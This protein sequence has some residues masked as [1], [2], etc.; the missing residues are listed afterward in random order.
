MEFFLNSELKCLK[1]K[2]NN[3]VKT[4]YLTAF[5]SVQP[6]LETMALRNINDDIENSNLFEID[7]SKNIRFKLKQLSIDIFGEDV[8][9]D[10]LTAFLQ[11]HEDS[12]EDLEIGKNF[13]DA[14]YEFSFTRF[15]N[16]KRLTINA[17][18]IPTDN[19]FYSRLRPNLSIKKL[20][21]RG[22]LKQFTTKELF[23][24]FPNI[25]T[26]VI[27]EQNPDNEE[28]NMSNE[29]MIY[30]SNNLNNLKHLVIPKLPLDV[31]ADTLKFPALKSFHVERMIQK[32]DW[33]TFIQSNPTIERLSFRWMMFPNIITDV[34]YE[35]IAKSLLNLQHL[36]LGSGITDYKGTLTNIAL[37]CRSLKV[38][39]MMNYLDSSVK[40]M[41]VLSQRDKEG[42]RISFYTYETD[43]LTFPEEIHLWSNEMKRQLF[44]IDGDDSSSGDS[45]G[46]EG[47]W[48]N[49]WDSDDELM[50]INYESSDNS[51]DDVVIFPFLR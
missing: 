10:Y 11:K 13:G 41:E 16:L 42:L 36:T 30:M 33:T 48:Q 44:D 47:D 3:D 39:Q 12:L 51:E 14:I 34:E 50:D 8:S 9:V 27:K 31:V 19:R 43:K 29:L 18:K 15:R 2:S 5:L 46:S 37:N 20:I 45:T 17:D 26:L 49:D 28:M 32:T 1:I 4:E 35:I 25:E 38:L 6:H 40:P 22:K 23:G 7:I 24:Q 21:I